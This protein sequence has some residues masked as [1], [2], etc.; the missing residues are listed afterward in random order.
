[1]YSNS[2]KKVVWENFMKKDIVLTG[3]GGQGI[4]TIAILIV[5]AAVNEGFDF[6]QSEMH[7]MNQ[8][9]GTVES[10]VRLSDRVIY[11]DIVPKGSADIII[12]LEPIEAL[13]Q[14]EYLSDDGIIIANNNSVKNIPDYPED[15]DIINMFRKSEKMVHLLDAAGIAKE[16]G[17]IHFQN[18]VLLGAASSYLGL[19]KK[20]LE[21]SICEFFA[22]KGSPV[23][24]INLRAF[25]RGAREIQEVKTKGQ[26]G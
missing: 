19:K 10:H 23:V 13:R 7:G 26:R 22:G 11:S 2:A 1:L 12:G 15:A 16:A 21:F 14:I 4:L 25:D 17:S 6:R 5:K 24:N 8:K 3:V 18:L 20:V 9:G